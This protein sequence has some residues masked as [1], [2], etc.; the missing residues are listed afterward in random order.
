MEPGA[1]VASSNVLCDLKFF[2]N[3]HFSIRK[4]AEKGVKLN[5]FNLGS[6]TRKAK[7]PY[8]ESVQL[9]TQIE[10]F[11]EILSLSNTCNYDSFDD[12]DLW[13]CWFAFAKAWDGF[14]SELADII[15]VRNDFCV[16]IMITWRQTN[17]LSKQKSCGGDKTIKTHEKTAIKKVLNINT[18]RLYSAS[19]FTQKTSYHA[20]NGVGKI[21]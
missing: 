2:L 9:K 5:A 17:T 13:Y 16:H 3:L 18:L 19:L 8:L 14:E 10:I 12:V 15:S 11:K 20:F 7:P 6:E 4:S 21:V 1:R